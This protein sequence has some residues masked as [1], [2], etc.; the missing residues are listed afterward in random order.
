MS[1]GKKQRLFSPWRLE[2]LESEKP[3]GCFLCKAIASDRDAENLV[4]RRDNSVC[5]VLNRY[6]YNN[7]HVMIVPV[8]HV[9]GF[10]ELERSEL[11]ELIY[12]V[13]ESEK[14]IKKM[15]RADGL[16]IGVN[17][18]SAAGAGLKD[19]LHIHL[20]PRW[21]GDTNF[22][23]TCADVR[24]IPEE[25]ATTW[26]RLHSEFGRINSSGGT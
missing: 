1:E 3:E 26:R 22:M 17:L 10:S 20:L 5:V 24:V 8:R 13:S 16:N 14:I 2:Y 15:Y 6:P 9:S 4:V 18:G 21:N 19:H 11:N 7:G 23:L 12:W 25:L